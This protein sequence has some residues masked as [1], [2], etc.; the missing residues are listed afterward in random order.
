MA[1]ALLTVGVYAPTF[2]YPFLHFD[3]LDYVTQNRHVAEGLSAEGVGWAFTTFYC[4]NWHP[5]TWLSLQ[6][7]CQL[8][9]GLKAGGFHVTNVLLHAAST[10]VLFLVLSRLTGG[11]WQSAMVAALFGV[12]PLNVEP[13]AWIAERKG[14]LSTLFWML[15]LGAYLYY[16]R[17]PGVARYLLV[18]LGLVLGLMAKPLLLTLPCV[19][20]L[21]DYWPLRRWRSGSETR[22]ADA[23]W[24]FLLLEKVPLL[25][26][27]LAWSAVAFLSQAHVKALPS[28]DK[29]PLNLRI[30]NGLQAYVVY[31]G[32]MLWPVHLA[33]YYP[34]PGTVLSIGSVVGAG[35]ILGILTL[36]VFGPGRRWPYLAV[37]WLWYLVTL[38]PMI[39]LV[40]IGAHGMA[41]RYTYVPLIG[42]FLILTWGVADLVLAWQLPR[43]TLVG[44]AVAVLSACVPLTS[45]QLGFWR[46]DRELW[47]HA[48]AVTGQNAMAHNNL[49]MCQ[50]RDG[51]PDLAAKEF[52][53]AVALDPG[54]ALFHHNLATLL[55]DLGHPEE[56]LTECH[57]AIE[58]D[59]SEAAFHVTL[60]SLLR[61]TGHPTESLA[62]LHEANRL[63]PENPVA[64]DR[65]GS[66]LWDLGRTN[67]A[68][69]AFR[70]AIKLDPAFASPHVGL[71]I[72]LAE[73]ERRPEACEEFRKAAKLDPANAL[74][75]F[76]LAMALQ[77]DGHLED[78]L[79]EYRQALEL[80]YRPAAARLRAC[81]RLHALGPRL[82]A[83]L[84]GREHPA[85]N[86]ERLAF[87]DL[88]AQP[89]V[90]H[91]AFAARFY[92][93]AFR[94]EP[95]LT[96]DLRAAY[97]SDA[98]IAAARAG[99]GQGQEAARLDEKA[100]T[101]LRGQALQW[102]QGELALWITEARSTI[103]QARTAVRQ[104]LYTWRRS[105]G[106]AGVREEPA[107]AKLPEPEA[108]EWRKLWQQVEAIMATK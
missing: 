42:L 25:A 21:L 13:V 77:A 37:G 48:L 92:A 53:Q 2:D 6:L 83:V 19:L 71:G 76:N 78:A 94:T 49:G 104:I 95:K 16:V 75:H 22:S 30:G 99:C 96:E 44:T 105:P 36:L 50:Y 89:F 52:E 84:A 55:R 24:R 29:Y 86:A 61:V 87:A 45:A 74:P 80:G 93:D 17:R 34:H 65:L 85:D 51:R 56:A 3:D 20:L 31:L 81:T 88:C 14:V 107:L 63:D 47:Q 41:D 54:S 106:L 9:G 100:K 18:V 1:L 70:T 27:V 79:T 38:V 64:Q 8:Y 62:E 23:S 11:I 26:V 73:L 35:L 5:L 98:A 108:K 43:A 15:T 39:G 91:Y 10:I 72:A 97:R 32:K 33:A 57:R 46:G 7:D 4:G 69:T 103:P 82:P 67:K 40:Q 58:L 60:A 101:E 59:R 28:L 68:L 90:G 66:L 12:H 102:L